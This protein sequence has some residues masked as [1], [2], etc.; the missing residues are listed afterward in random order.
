MIMTERDEYGDFEQV[1][2]ATV[3]AAIRRAE[4]AEQQRDNLLEALKELAG[5]CALAL[6][7]SVRW[8]AYKKARAIIAEVEDSK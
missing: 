6:D 4:M 5:T 7:G 3:N 8:D 2:G 1:N